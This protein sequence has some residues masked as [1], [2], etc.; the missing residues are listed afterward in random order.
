ML[1][2]DTRKRLTADECLEHAFLLNADEKLV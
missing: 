2:L 1:D